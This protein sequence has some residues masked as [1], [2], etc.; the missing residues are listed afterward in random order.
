M[1]DIRERLR[2]VERMPVPDQWHDIQAREPLHP[3]GPRLGTRASAMI[4]G[5]V[6]GLLAILVVQQAFDGKRSVEPRT[7]VPKANGKVAF[8][9]T[10]PESL[11]AEG[12]APDTD[13]YVVDPQTTQA[14]RLVAGVA[15]NIPPAWSP[16][17]T[18]LAY[19]KNDALF[20]LHLDDSHSQQLVACEPPAC[21]GLTAA[22]WSPDGTKIAFGQQTQD[23]YGL[24][25]ANADGTG[26]MLLLENL[27]FAVPTWSPD[28]QWVAVSGSLGDRENEGIFIIDSES[29]DIVRTI[30]V[31]GLDL[32]WNLGWSPDGEWLVFDALGAGGA[33]S[34]DPVTDAGIYLVR[35][36]GTDRSLLTSWTCPT[37]V[38]RALDPSWSPDGQEIVFTRSMPEPGSDGSLGD[39]YSIDVD[40][41][42][43]RELT[44][45]PGLDCCGSWQPVPAVGTSP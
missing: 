15:H 40:S 44:R 14:E 19:V 41:G 20:T 33:E 23:S 37:N 21:H 24:W 1:S 22:A 13:L 28:G 35:A 29:G 6:V 38:C 2:E 3:S 36:D 39:L 31:T 8:L 42:E 30:P 10:H 34:S 17:G 11:I 18:Q 43:V 4:T 26:A 5:I 7:T 32:G 9:R 45:G 25:I 12:G 27:L 16:D